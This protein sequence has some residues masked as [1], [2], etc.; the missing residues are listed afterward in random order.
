MFYYRGAT[1]PPEY[2]DNSF[3]CEPAGNLVHRD[4]I[5]PTNSTFVARRAQDGV[6]FLVSPDNWCRPVNITSGPD[7]A[8][9]VCDMYR[10]T[11]EHPDY[12]P[13]A[14]RKITDFDSGKNMGR[15]YRVS[16]KTEIKETTPELTRATIKQLCDTLNHPDGWW[17]TTAQRLILERKD[18]KAVPYLKTLCKNAK[19]PETRV[20]ALWLWTTQRPCPTA[21]KLRLR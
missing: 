6:E 1:L 2:R 11:I 8:L 19:M 5:S 7:G 3:T 17:R 14:T 9:Y 15:I 10:K 4:V 12:L 21:N 20:Q 18:A 13:E 16:A